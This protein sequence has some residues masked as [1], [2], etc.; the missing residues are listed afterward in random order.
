MQRQRLIKLMCTAKSTV[1][2][3]DLPTASSA[4]PLRKD[5]TDTCVPKFLPTPM[6]LMRSW[7][8]DQLMHIMNYYS[9]TE[10]WP[11]VVY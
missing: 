4:P 10:F 2:P 5:C 11:A 1:P 7:V 8:R 9:L 6:S 3:L